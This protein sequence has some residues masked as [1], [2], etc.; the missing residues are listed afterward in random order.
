M[1]DKK[2][3]KI[4]EEIEKV[5]KLI[6]NKKNLNLKNITKLCK[7]YNEIILKL[8]NNNFIMINELER[9]SFDKNLEKE[10]T[11][12][13]DKYAQLI[14]VKNKLLIMLLKKEYN[15]YLEEKNNQL[16]EK[17]E[18][19]IEDEKSYLFELNEENE[20]LKEVK[21]ELKYLEEQ[22]NNSDNLNEENIKNKQIYE[23]KEKEIKESI[24]LLDMSILIVRV[25]IKY[26]KTQIEYLTK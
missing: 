6:G 9:I 8:E 26:L 20:N 19:L 23:K 3:N 22:I 1:I 14:Y 17:L 10:N 12:L 15:E 21:Y 5:N 4:I 11:M 7:Q 24:E 2:N 25:E 13:L 18:Q 16:K